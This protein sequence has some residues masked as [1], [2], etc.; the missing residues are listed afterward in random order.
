MSTGT[1]LVEPGRPLGRDSIYDANSYLLAAAVRAH[2]GIAYRV[3][4][5]PTT[6]PRSPRRSATSWRGPTSW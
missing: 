1:E 2:G 5:A 6:P 3:G 4:R